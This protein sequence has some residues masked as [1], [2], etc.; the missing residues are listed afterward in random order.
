MDAV[1]QASVAG[2]HW[3]D[4]HPMGLEI[5][6]AGLN[7][8]LCLGRHPTL[9]APLQS[10]LVRTQLFRSK[11]RDGLAKLLSECG[12]PMLIKR[13][14]LEMVE[15]C[16]DVAADI[17]QWM[18]STEH[19]HRDLRYLIENTNFMQSLVKI[20][21]VPGQDDRNVYTR[22]QV[23]ASAAKIF[24]LVG[25]NYCPSPTAS[26]VL[27]HTRQAIEALVALFEAVSI[28]CPVCVFNDVDC[29][30]TEKPDDLHGGTDSGMRRGTHFACPRSC[31]DGLTKVSSILLS[32]GT[33]EPHA[34]ADWL[35]LAS[36]FVP[37]I[38]RTP[39]GL[40]PLSSPP[41]P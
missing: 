37:S 18:T 28:C 25:P 32:A 41:E 3:F 4:K 30:T 10:Y 39:R 29:C 27:P 26:M 1:V 20:L 6:L 35:T 15:D 8:L 9:Q 16:L 22:G 36:F 34:T 24:W 13:W 33:G 2:L 11:M 38:T 21:I 19:F 17:F 7:I 14:G 31:Q 23:R 12:Q 40:W 5:A